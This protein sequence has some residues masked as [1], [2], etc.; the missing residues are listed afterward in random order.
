[1]VDKP[2]FGEPVSPSEVPATAQ[3]ASGLPEPAEGEPLERTTRR[4]QKKAVV[5]DRVARVEALVALP[6]PDFAQLSLP[7]DVE[8]E[9]ILARR[10]KPSGAKARQIR[11]IAK[12]LAGREDVFDE[13]DG[14]RP[15]E[16]WAERIRHEGDVAIEALLDVCPEAERQ[17]I[18]QALR[19]ADA[20]RLERYLAQ[21]DPPAPEDDEEPADPP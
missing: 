12:L 1:M 16:L 19:A 5:E 18:H 7:D 2:P 14:P 4:R 13:V 8:R 21:L 9:L 6:E 10:L 20:T 11:Y 17:R 15:A 3:R